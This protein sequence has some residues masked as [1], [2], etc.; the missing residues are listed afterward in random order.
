M[1]FTP[2]ELLAMLL[3]VTS[4]VGWLNRRYW[5]LPSSVGLLAVGLVGASVLFGVQRLFPGV[6]SAGD[7][8]GIV[9]RFDFSGALLGF[10]LAY[11]LFAGAVHTDASG[12]ARLPVSISLLSTLG[13]LVST[14]VTA[15]GLWLA[16]RAIGVPLP[17]AW[18]AVFGALISPTDPVAVLAAF[19]GHDRTGKVKSLMQGESLFNDGFG[20]VVFGAMLS[21]ATGHTPS[22]AQSLG[23]TAIEVFG[24]GAVGAAFG[25]LV[26]KLMGGIDDPS[27]ETGL[28]MALATGAYAVANRFHASGPIAVVVAGLIVGSQGKRVAMSDRTQ[29][30]LLGFWE[31][32]DDNLNAILF[33]LVGLEVVVAFMSLG[34]IV[35][36]A[37]VSILIVAAA[38]TVAVAPTIA[39]LVATRELPIRQGAVVVWGG[40]RGGISVALAL[41]IPASPQRGLI[42]TCTC[43]VVIFSVLVQGLTFPR[44]ADWAARGGGED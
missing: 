37:I 44:V 25:W 12:L 13:V 23:R 40:L 9:A 41:S 27:V 6:E 39:R 24:G 18:A 4:V 10:M 19:R 2:L 5:Q 33:F 11:L 7:L 15:V 28:S 31:L 26:L 34:V 35:E 42:V 20:V 8:A 43:A 36:L 17:L 29:R 30:Y 14:G 1:Y 38:R 32:V 3:G 16:A 22:I 21:I